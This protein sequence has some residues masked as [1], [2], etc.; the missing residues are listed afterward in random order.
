MNAIKHTL[1][2]NWNFMRVFRLGVG[3]FIAIEAIKTQN[4]F[5]GLIALFFLYQSIVNTGCCG[6]Q[7]CATNLMKNNSAKTEDVEFEEVK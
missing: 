1:M 2:S 6:T 5:S 7:G 4:I 3:I